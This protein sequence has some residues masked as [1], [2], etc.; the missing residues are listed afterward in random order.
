VANVCGRCHAVFQSRFVTSVHAQLFT[1]TQCHSNHDVKQVSDAM[2]G[3]K[4]P[5]L[6]AECHSQGDAGFAAAQEMRAGIDSLNAAIDQSSTLIDRATNAGMELGDQSLALD[7]ARNQL[8]LARTTMHTFDAA[9]VQ[10][11]VAK[12]LEITTA[13]DTAGEAALGEVHFRRTGL[14]VSLVAI[15]VVVVALA[16]KIRQID[17][18]HGVKS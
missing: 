13:V 3:T 12:G 1:C 11:V 6:C 5:A 9:Q 15:L 8:S 10:T 14:G 16:L 2:L 17:R 18:A 7:Q 4:P